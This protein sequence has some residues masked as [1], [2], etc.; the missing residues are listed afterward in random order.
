MLE[1]AKGFTIIEVTI[2]LGISGLLLVGMFLGTGT[3]VAQQR[4]KDTTDN[5]QGYFQAQ[6]EEVVNGVNTRS[7]GVV[8]G[9]ASTDP[10]RSGCLLL[11]KV[12]TVSASGTSIQ[13]SYIIS[14]VSLTGTEADDSARLIRAGLKVVDAGQTTYELKWG[15]ELSQV[16][17]STPLISQPGRGA[18]N[19]IAFV[20]LPDSGRIVQL[21]YK[22]T[23]GY[24]TDNQ[25]S[26]LQETVAID[27][28]AYSP[29]TNSD[30]DPS[31]AVCVKNDKD[32]SI[33]NYRSAI[34]FGQGKGAGSI[35]TM[36][37]PG[38][39]CAL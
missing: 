4:F 6:Y 5:L 26:A 15:A 17:R 18:V 35:T 19:S 36:Y 22:N 33:A 31:L 38:G 30:T 25:T 23:K 10:G 29:P 14:T 1:G 2:F 39:L 20:Q 8:C 21:Y 7:S 12:L 11:G 27:A 9:A 37:E 24:T 16:T 13:A 28:S 3:L 32:F 34:K